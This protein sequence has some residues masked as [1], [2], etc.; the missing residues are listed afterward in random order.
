MITF[1]IDPNNNITAHAGL[2]A[3]ADN[4]QSFTTARELVKLAAEWPNTRLVEIWNSFAGVAPFDDLK[5]V[6]KFTSRKAAVARIWDAVQ[7]LNP[8]VAQPAGNVAP[9]Q[10]KLRKGAAKGNR[11]TTPRP[12]AKQTANVARA[13][14]KKAAILALL[15]RTKG[16]T[17]AEIMKATGWLPHTVRG[18]ISGTIAKKLGLNVESTRAEGKERAYRITG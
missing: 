10:P 17:A 1:T 8:D 12:I 11:R 15:R 3:S 2:P 9:L 6:K 13:G 16:A 18:F 4:L 5:T 14:S 7:R